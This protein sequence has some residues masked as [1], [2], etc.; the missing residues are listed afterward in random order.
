MPE[1]SGLDLQQMLNQD[2]IK[3]PMIIITGHGDVPM[4]VR[5][6]KEGA[7][8]FIEK[9]FHYQYLLDSI[10]RALAKSNKRPRSKLTGY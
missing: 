2:E 1:T 9:P 8:D 10:A 4:A 7:V 3:I 5:A 6:M